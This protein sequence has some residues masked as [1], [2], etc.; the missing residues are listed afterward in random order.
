M[1]RRRLFLLP[2]L[3][4]TGIPPGRSRAASR[5]ALG[6]R[7]VPGARYVVTVTRLRE[8]YDGGL[9]VPEARTG[10][11]AHLE[12]V[13]AAADGTLRL[14]WRWRRYG[15]REPVEGDDRG[16]PEDPL[17]R[18]MARLWEAVAFAFTVDG[19]GRLVGLADP[20]A[21]RRAVTRAVDGALADVRARLLA[22]G[23]PAPEVDV[24]LAPLRRR[25][26][27]PLADDAGLAA[28]LLREPAMLFELGGLAL[29]PGEER[30]ST[31]D[32]PLDFAPGR[33]HPM[34]L[35]DRLLWYEEDTGTVR[36]ERVEEPAVPLDRRL[37]LDRLPGL[38]AMWR[39][40]PEAARAEVLA[41]L[42]ETHYRRVSRWTL[43]V[44]GDRLPREVVRVERSA[45][46]TLMRRLRV[47]LRLRRLDDG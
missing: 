38:A 24:A 16:A 7:P 15:V 9:W 6:P 14:R 21:A 29:A 41:A 1:D 47:E 5:L 10:A 2:A 8:V 23:K 18:R 45:L 33:T 26:L 30:R 35:R 20:V 19:A 28:E 44:V 39:A 31:A 27:A 25:L 32:R 37:L 34:R 13:T 42:P 36:V 46:G 4:L 40:L 11:G 12:V 22:E 43:P 3:V 17:R